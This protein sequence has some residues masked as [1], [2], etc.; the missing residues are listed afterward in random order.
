MI[1]I[2][3]KLLISVSIIAYLFMRADLNSVFERMKSADHLLV[4]SSTCLFLA[5]VIP[6][7]IRWLSI[8]KGAGAGLKLR[9][10][11]GIT[12]VGWFFNQ[13]LPSSVGGDAFRVWYAYR[14]GIRLS[15]ATQ[16]VI[17]DRISALIAIM[18]ILLVMSPWL[19]FF[20]SSSQPVFTILLFASM[21][22]LGCITLLIADRIIPSFLPDSVKENVVEF[23]RTARQVFLCRIGLRVIALSVAIH[24]I[25]ALVV[26]LL[27]KSLHIPLDIFHV[28]LLMPVILFVTAIPISIAGWGVRESTM[29]IVF[30]MVGVPDESAISLSLSF[31]LVML[32]A[33]LPGGVVWWFMHHEVPQTE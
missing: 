19:K 16:S 22:L 18:F 8:L 28:L 31:G 33:S 10:A 14:F 25:V 7:S 27:A 3:I 24:F 29:V 6:Q 9:L 26:W 20:F 23:S 13:V 11:T 15:T 2:L 5:L 17:F 21:L 1:K 12:L 32:V 4:I 30:G